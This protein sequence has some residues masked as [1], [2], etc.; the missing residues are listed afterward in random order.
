M[1]FHVDRTWT[2][3][4]LDYRWI[5]KG[6]GITEIKQLPTQQLKPEHS[7]QQLRLK[8]LCVLCIDP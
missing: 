1:Y 4:V 8:L 5:L 3:R 2:R 6:R 7:T